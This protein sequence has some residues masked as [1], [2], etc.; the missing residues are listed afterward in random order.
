MPV[1]AWMRAWLDEG[2]T[3]K[4]MFD[5]LKFLALIIWRIRDS[6]VDFFA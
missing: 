6:S 1:T 2:I 5:G 3:E 4:D